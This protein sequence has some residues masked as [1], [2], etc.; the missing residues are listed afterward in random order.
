VLK[1]L[2]KFWRGESI[3]N[4]L[5]AE[6]T[7]MIDDGHWMFRVATE[8]V[9]Q[10]V[11]F[12]ERE[13]ALYKRDKQINSA[14]RLIRRQ[15]V[16]HLTLNPGSDVPYCLVLMSIVKDAERIGDYCKNIFDVARLFTRTFDHGRYATPLQ[17]IR[18]ALD[19]SFGSVKEAFARENEVLAKDIVRKNKVVAKK[20]E[21]LITQLIKDEIA[22]D[23]AVA[24]T[25]VSRHFKRVALHL[26][27]IATSVVVPVH[28]L[29]YADEVLNPKR[30]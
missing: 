19:A 16:E 1:E 25:L 17:E 4:R 9:M 12:Q 28:E 21:L 22:T 30:E 11:D 8:A 7:K 10:E 14:Q 6:F 26:S 24:Y 27:N 3:L 2:L 13:D 23:Q 29:D 20:C 18:S 15:V 5:L